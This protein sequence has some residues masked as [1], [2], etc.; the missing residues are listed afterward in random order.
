M[1]KYVTNFI[2]TKMVARKIKLN[3]I[4]YDGQS[5]IYLHDNFEISIFYFV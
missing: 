3:L 1:K 2:E 4:I 5:T